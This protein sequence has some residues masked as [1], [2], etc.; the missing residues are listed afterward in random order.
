MTIEKILEL[1]KKVE[2]TQ[3]INEVTDFIKKFETL[4]ED[5]LCEI[6]IFSGEN[7]DLEFYHFNQ[8]DPHS[9]DSVTI[10]FDGGKDISLYW[11][12]FVEISGFRDSNSD[13]IYEDNDWIIYRE[14]EFNRCSEII[15]KLGYEK[16][17][18]LTR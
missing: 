5:I 8:A 12:K 11:Y 14:T 6:A 3:N 16:V 13:L 9:P 1:H 2:D 17:Q 4:D 10:Y 15:E 7:G 18:E